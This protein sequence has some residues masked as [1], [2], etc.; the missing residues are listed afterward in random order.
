MQDLEQGRLIQ[1]NFS[2]NNNTLMSAIGRK[3]TFNILNKMNRRKFLKTG[4]VSILIAGN[5][6]KANP[7][8]FLNRP[9]PTEIEGPFYPVNAQKD[10]DFDL[11]NIEGHEQKAIGEHIYIVGSVLDLEGQPVENALVDIWQANAAGK[12]AHPYDPNPAPVDP[13]FQ[14]WAIVSSGKTGEFRFKT[15]LP[16]A[17]PASGNWMRPPH[18]HFK[19]S[20]KGYVDL[21]TQMYFPKQPLNQVDKL[22]QRKNQEEQKLMIAKKDS[23]KP[24]TYYYRLFIQKS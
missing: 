17:Y 4:A 18:I 20:K 24:D 12:Y 19:V 23:D 1:E 15:V 9:T 3:R 2:V 6:V 13:N 8:K 14:G 7:E 16:G 10:K 5:Q 22:L 21:V 11:T